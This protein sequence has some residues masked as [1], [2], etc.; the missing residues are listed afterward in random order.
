MANSTL[1]ISYSPF[2]SA[3]S[4]LHSVGWKISKVNVRCPWVLNVPMQSLGVTCLFKILSINIL[5][6]LHY[7]G[8]IGWIMMP[9]CSKIRIVFFLLWEAFLFCCSRAEN[10]Y[11]KNAEFHPHTISKLSQCKFRVL[12]GIYVDSDVFSANTEDF[13]I[14]R[15]LQSV[16]SWLQGSAGFMDK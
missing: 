13:F 14:S 1:S 11:S 5:P 15:E 4:D 3:D 16:V 10:V 2:S 6:H 9:L 8:N 12:R 7:M